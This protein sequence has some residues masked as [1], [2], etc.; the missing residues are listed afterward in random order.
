MISHAFH[1][2]I[3][4]KNIVGLNFVTIVCPL[5]SAIAAMCWRQ[6]SFLAET[7]GGYFCKLC[8]VGETHIS[9]VAV[10]SLCAQNTYLFAL[11]PASYL[12]ESFLL[13]ILQFTI[14]SV[15]ASRLLISL[16]HVQSLL[17]CKHTNVQY[18]MFQGSLLLCKYV[19]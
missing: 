10:A 15:T 14:T 6:L 9:A 18:Y 13:C 16:L 2:Q 11:K 17:L 7:S 3:Q 12:F 1:M 19:Q 5:S 8:R 4:V